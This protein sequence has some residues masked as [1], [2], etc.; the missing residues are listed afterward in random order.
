MTEVLHSRFGGSVIGRVIACPGSVALCATVPPAPSSLYARDGSGAHKLGEIC[1]KKDMHPAEFLGVELAFEDDGPPVLVTQE[2]VDAV[3]V[4]LEAVTHELALTKTAELYVE[5]GFVLDIKGAKPGEVFGTNDAMVYHPETGRLRVF[6]YKHGV[7]VSVSA[8]DNAQL[9]FYAAGAV[10][11]NKWKV[12]EL[13]LTIV[14]PRARDADEVG[15]VKDWTFETPD[16][17]E[18]LGD[19]S[20][21]VWE[22][23]GGCSVD[24]D[25]SLPRLAAGVH[26]DKSFCDARVVCPAY[27]ALKLADTGFENVD[28]TGLDAASYPEPAMLTDERLAQ[29]VAALSR[30][31]TW[32]NTCQEYLEARLLAG[33]AV[34]GW[35]VVDKIGRAKWISDEESIAASLELMF[36][37]DTDLVRPRRLTTIG[38][39]EKLLKGA[40]ATKDQINSFKLKNTLKES[41]GRTIA[42]E[43]D[44]RPAINAAE[45]AFGDVNV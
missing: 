26:C 16:L 3:L 8:D 37:I 43:S 7:G 45:R 29:I 6:D 19:V 30:F 34:P 24:K 40:G 4:Y 11:S 42:P 1:L 14:Q 25:A 9:K 18:F 21:A 28:L 15:A 33:H 38:D 17:F 22:A 20:V 2:M 32:A 36:D 23:R 31:S 5:K 39:V 12:G 41:S 10:F 35:K 44:R 27:Q 13:V